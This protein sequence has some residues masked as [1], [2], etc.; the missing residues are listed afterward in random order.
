MHANPFRPRI[1]ALATAALLGS[2]LPSYAQEPDSLLAC[3]QPALAPQIRSVP[4]RD[5]APIDIRADIFDAQQ[6]NLS[7]AIGSVE[8]FRAD[9]YLATEVIRYRPST[10][11]VSVPSPLVYR[12]AQIELEA[13][14]GQFF[15]VEEKGDFNDLQYQLVGSSAQGGAERVSLTGRRQSELFNLWF[16]TCP[17][18]DPEWM[19]SARELE[20]RHEDGVGVARGA[21]LRLGDVP[22]LYLPWMTFPID[23]RRKT[24]F[25]YPSIGTANDNGLELSIPF[26]WNI[27]PHQDATIEPTW[28]SN[29][30]IM[31]TTEY[32]Y[33]T[34]RTYSVLDVDYMPSDRRADD[35]RWHY[36]ARWNM[37]INRAWRAGA[38]LERVSDNEFF[39]DF[40]GNLA[41]TSRQFLRSDA[42][43]DGA[44]RYWIFT[45]LVDDFQVIDDAVGADEEPYSRFPR[46]TYLLDAPLG[47]SGLGARLDAEA[48]YFHRDLGVTGGRVDLLPSL[49]WNAQRR[50]GF[51]TA[52]AG[53]RYT[54]Y[55]LDLDGEPGDASPDR[56]TPIL[57]LDSGVYLERATASGNRQTLEPRLFYLY[58]PFEEQSALP[59]F[60][61]RELTFGYAQLFHTNR[62]V[63]ADRQSDA[64]QITL[65]ATTRA[66]RG[67]DG[68]ER[69]NF[70]FGQIVYLESPRVTLDEPPMNEDTSP[71]IG[72]FNWHPLDRTSARLGIQWNWENRE[73]DVGVAAIDHRARNGSRLAFEYRFRRDRV[74]QFDVRYLWPVNENWRLFSR[75]SYSLDNSSLLEGLVGVEYDSCCWALRVAVRRYLRDRN[76]GERDALYAELRLK[77][78]GAFGR[79]EPALFHTPAP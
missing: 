29:R 3:P 67:R 79:R 11:A 59:D 58:V 36:Q 35:E 49:A 33:L 38:R 69:W 54:A 14:S 39:Q 66:F 71:F 43:L 55:D 65:A 15:I 42:S 52:R 22:V 53:Y 77:G 51:F 18:D 64:N 6:E 37:A 48:V 32:R 4:D 45:A 46:F 16:T 40:G 23:D 28:Y 78:L 24:G 47:R 72:E 5:N 19:L 20:L 62:F 17:G 31:L 8:L 10:G 9:Q 41:Q 63:G 60:D 70:S 50:W 2:S 76:G 56:G 73:L 44:G 26:Y 74:D 34:R 1:A 75:V 25:L 13:S 68:R 7:E 12:D 61:T 30:G 57:S 21:K 27:A